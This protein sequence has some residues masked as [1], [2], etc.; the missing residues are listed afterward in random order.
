MSSEL[1]APFLAA[2][3]LDLVLG[4]PPRWPHPVRWIGKISQFWEGIIYRPT[5]WAGIVFWSV[6]MGTVTALTLALIYVL[7]LFPGPAAAPIEAYLIYACLATRSLHLESRLVEEA[8]VLGNLAEA[9]RRLSSIVGRETDHLTTE[10]VRR[11]TIETVAENLSDGVVAPM[12]YGVLLGVP[13]MILYKGVNTL[14]SMVGYRNERYIAFGRVP[15]RADDILNY[16]PSRL[17]ALLMA[18]VATI[19]KMDG[20]G[21]L[22]IIRRDAQKASSPNAGWPEAAMA[23]VLNVRLGGPS[24]YSGRLVQKSLIGDPAHSLGE[25]D[26]VRAIRLLYGTSILMAALV[27]GLLIWS[28]C[29]IW[30]VLLTIIRQLSF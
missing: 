28:G 24:I 5:V 6:V 22:R 10:E 26:Y 18:C 20:A 7:Y 1:A 13:G 19:L 16:L 25:N 2:Y 8:L 3:I 14:D 12:F 9:R 11:A 21:A 29:G 4:D 15:A 23:G 17:T 30:G 27:F